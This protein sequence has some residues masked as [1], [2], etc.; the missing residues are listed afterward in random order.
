MFNLKQFSRNSHHNHG[1]SAIHPVFK[2][3]YWQ[4]YIESYLRNDRETTIKHTPYVLTNF[5]QKSP[6]V[7]TIQ[8]FFDHLQ[9][10]QPCSLEIIAILKSPLTGGDLNKTFYILRMFQLSTEG[11][12]LTNSRIDKLGNKLSYVGSENWDNVLCYM[13]ALLF[14]MFANLD[15]FE[16]ILF[17]PN[18]DDPLVAQLSALLRV[19]V[20]LLRS[21]YLITTDL[22]ARVCEG[23]M[24]LGYSEAL[25]HKQ[26]DAATLFEFLTEVLNMPLL[27]F[28]VDIKHGG[29]FNKNDDQKIS[30]ERILFVSIPDEDDGV[31]KKEI[32]DDTSDSDKL[33]RSNSSL[34]SSGSEM[35]ESILL[36]ECLEHYFNN[37][38]SVKRELERRASLSNVPTGNTFN[39]IPENAPTAET[40]RH[41]PNKHYVEEVENIEDEIKL[42]DRSDSRK[43]DGIRVRARTRSSTLS[44]WSIN[45]NDRKDPKKP[46]E[47]NLPAWMF[48]RLLPFYTDDN[49]L[50]DSFESTAKSSKDFANRRPVLPIC[51]K[52][53]HMHSGDLSG[54]KSHKRIIIPPFIDLPDFVADD[55]DGPVSSF[56][57]ILESAICHRGKT[58][59]SGH[60]VAVVRKNIEETSQSEDE[61]YDSKWLLYD[62]MKKSSRVVEKTFREIFA[63]EW[64]YMLFYRLVSTNETSAVSSVK[65]D[66]IP[67][68]GIKP[69]YWDQ[70]GK[71]L[72]SQQVSGG[73]SLSLS[74]ILSTNGSEASDQVEKQQAPL[75]VPKVR[76]TVDSMVS[77]VS[78]ND[79]GYIDIRNRYF[80]FI[81]DEN[82]NYYK[83][84]VMV[85]D[86]TSSV[87][88]SP[89]FRRNSQWS[90]T[91]NISNIQ[92]AKSSSGQLPEKSHS[93]ALSASTTSETKHDTLDIQND[94][95][96]TTKLEKGST[97]SIWRRKKSPK[98]K[99]EY[100][101]P[102]EGLPQLQL[103]D[104][105]KQ[106]F[107]QTLR[108]KD[109]QTKHGTNVN[110]N[111]NHSHGLLH[112]SKRRRDAYKK[113]K[114]TIT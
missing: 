104:P 32:T 64:P 96:Q 26:Q 63:T 62:D 37:S 57:L 53:Y 84:E 44:I 24:K 41:D 69:K 42:R 91:S 28:K 111:Q 72:N 74:P 2:E 94:N 93:D 61:A 47:V 50:T 98:M 102:V 1:P 21:G 19:Y 5:T 99:A 6:E 76:I 101:E 30:K 65:S 88:F 106:T 40:T 81:P 54:T 108:N 68:N 67:Q 78:P 92:L 112:R 59:E 38:I 73:R 82:K 107:P 8:G 95:K 66:I 100:V 27:T 97:G 75:N 110:S 33:T 87:N 31:A 9:L 86:G 10:P 51:L 90:L 39:D 49:V 43:S 80:W 70:S 12:F 48:L 113:E 85:L 29:K 89:Q 77:P 83:E 58:I 22:T 4:W 71:T 18:Q 46:N 56:K 114:C 109:E 23:L 105:P 103:D 17:I 14:A 34:N 3:S 35:D 60:F 45:D 15:S 55:V 13:D 7:V 16:P 79:P 11:W 20:S 36:E 25:S 52:R